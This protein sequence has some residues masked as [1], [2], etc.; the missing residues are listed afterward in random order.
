[1]KTIKAILFDMDGVLVDSE[2][3]QFAAHKEALHHF[4]IEISK[5]EYISYGASASSKNFY[6]KMAELRKKEIDI[7]EVQKYK[8]ELYKKSRVQ[9][10]IMPGVREFLE[11]ISNEYKVAVV[12]G[13][14]RENVAATLKHAG[15]NQFFKVTVSSDDVENNK[16][17]PDGYLLA[18]ITL[19]VEPQ[20]CLVIEDSIN[21][22]IAG[23][24]A[25]MK[26]IAVPNEFTKRQDLSKADLVL[27]SM[28]ELREELLEKL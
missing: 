16:P 9:I 2:P 17:F 10:K 28:E 3:L 13:S 19:G 7:P 21:G 15:I 18:A 26:C 14:S 1:M 5:E 11:K 27:N 8:R 22:I 20:A 24:D 12:S 25:G 6:S 23:K 4:G